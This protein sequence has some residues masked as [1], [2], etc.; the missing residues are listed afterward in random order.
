MGRRI[1]SQE[2]H[3]SPIKYVIPTHG[4]WGHAGG[5]AAPRE[6]GSNVIAYVGFPK[7]LERSRNYRPLFQYLFGTSAMN[8]D[9]VP[10]RLI[11]ARKRSPMA[12][13]SLN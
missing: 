3:P 13:L 6:S 7:E 11:S 1:G 4:H 10:D 5:L 12:V 8:P 2:N 9:A